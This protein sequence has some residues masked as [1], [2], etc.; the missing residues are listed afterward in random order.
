MIMKRIQNTSTL[1]SLKYLIHLSELFLENQDRVIWCDYYLDSKKIHRRF[2]KRKPPENLS[3]QK[4]SALME[5][6]NSAS[7]RL[8]K[9]STEEKE[10]TFEN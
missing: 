9:T 2:R 7:T 1:A 8:A 4:Y 10:K 5:Q 6:M 3:C